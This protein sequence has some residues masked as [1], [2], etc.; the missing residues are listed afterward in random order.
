MTITLFHIAIRLLIYI[1]YL[2]NFKLNR[3]MYTYFYI[4]QLLKGQALQDITD[5]PKKIADLKVKLCFYMM[6]HK[7]FT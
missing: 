6:A 3:S 1:N 2:V 4:I 5:I 7:E